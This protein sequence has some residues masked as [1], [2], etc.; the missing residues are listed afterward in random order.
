[1][2]FDS[3]GATGQPNLP[4]S[5]R[6][7]VPSIDKEHHALVSQLDRLNDSPDAHPRSEV[8]LDILHQLGDA[9]GAHFDHEEAYLKSCGMPVHEVTEHVQAH[10]EILDQYVRLN[11][12]LM[13]GKPVVYAEVLLMIKRWII[14]HLMRHDLRIRSYVRAPST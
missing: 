7:G 2:S 3:T 11:L 6:I 10:T 5:L 14:D 4:P 8:F 1:M 9:I 12:D 13:E